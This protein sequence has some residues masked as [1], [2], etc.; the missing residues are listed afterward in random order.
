MAT[1]P[2]PDPVKAPTAKAA[3][4]AP[5]STAPAPKAGEPGGAGEPTG[6]FAPPP[7]HAPH[8]TTQPLQPEALQTMAEKA[9][10]HERE[11]APLKHALG[12]AVA[13]AAG[14]PDH[15]LGDHTVVTAPPQ[16][17]GS[18]PAGSAHLQDQPPLGTHPPI[19]PAAPA[20]SDTD[21]PTRGIP[22]PILDPGK[23]ITGGWGGAGGFE[24]QYY[25][26]DGTELRALVLSIWKELAGQLDI[27]L[28]FGI[29]CTYPQVAARVTIEI[30]G[31][32][33][34]AQVNDVA[35]TVDSRVL[36]LTGEK[37]DD[38]STPADA[39]RVEA[40]LERPFKRT[41]KTATG[42]F[43]VDR[44]PGADPLPVDIEHPPAA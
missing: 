18:A 17:A 1:T 31:A 3:P 34:S 35:F 37:V 28:R 2:K 15:P 27:D 25:A 40:G 5:A 8:E 19:I 32:H 23:Q 6:M 11:L 36:L 21:T 9:S 10:Q 39:L 7:A 41:I 26:L 43:I 14:A 13:S 16:A 12:K 38:Q 22:K 33:A 20:A 42:T 24:P 29:A 4:A 44:D 30:T